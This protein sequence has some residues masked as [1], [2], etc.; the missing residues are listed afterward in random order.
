MANR[1]ALILGKVLAELVGLR[2][3]NVAAALPEDELITVASPRICMRDGEDAADADRAEVCRLGAVT[4]G[5]G[6][7]PLPRLDVSGLAI[8]PKV[9]DSIVI[10]H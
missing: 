4:K 5:R 9:C 7:A 10:T 3:R 6:P 8:C 1:L 2:H